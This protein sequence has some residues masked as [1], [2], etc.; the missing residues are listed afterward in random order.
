MLHKQVPC[1][2]LCTADMYLVAKGGAA[3]QAACPPRQWSYSGASA[4]MARHGLFA[5]CLFAGCQKRI[6]LT[7]QANGTG[8]SSANQESATPTAPD[9]SSLRFARVKLQSVNWML[10]GYNNQF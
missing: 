5:G 1:L 4:H 9:R 2:V 10:V 7:T 3:S 6:S 8:F